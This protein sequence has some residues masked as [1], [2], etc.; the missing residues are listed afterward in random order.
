MNWN[1]ADLSF[2]N[3]RR[4]V[5]QAERFHQAVSREPGQ[6]A[7]AV[8]ATRLWIGHVVGRV[9]GGMRAGLVAPTH[10]H[11]GERQII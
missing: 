1:D 6:P 9:L 11:S 4:N 2:A 10:S 5:A 3:Q 7:A 8:G